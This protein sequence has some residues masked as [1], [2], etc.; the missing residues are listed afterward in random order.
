MKR[1]IIFLGMVFLFGVIATPLSARGW[2][3]MEYGP[4]MGYG[5]DRDMGHIMG[6][7]PIRPWVNPLTEEQRTQLDE[8]NKKF[9]E[10]TAAFREALADKSRELNTT[11]T[12]EE[13][14]EKKAKALQK[15]I[16]D[17]RAKL[18]EKRLDFRLETAKIIPESGLGR[19]IG[20]FLGMDPQMGGFPKRPELS[21]LTEK[22]RDQLN[23]LNKKFREETAELRKNLRSTFRELNSVLDS[24]KPDEK[25]AKALQEKISELRA[26]LSQKTLDLRLEVD[27][28]LPET[29]YARGYRR[30]FGPHRGYGPHMGWDRGMS[31]GRG[32]G[33][34]PGLY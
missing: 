33:R 1:L 11:L 18:S 22:Q 19:G 24:E 20:R 7:F 4:F 32:M 14:D 29:E 31:R 28:I 27:K 12:S 6:R 23:E 21:P 17:L 2:R 30:G 34:A 25:E 9:Q 8:L 16:S 26:E 3:G 13:P 15:E 10:E 5:P